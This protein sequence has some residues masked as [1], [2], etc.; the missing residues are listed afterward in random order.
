MPDVRFDVEA[1]SI[2]KQA[3]GQLT[4]ALDREL[5]VGTDTVLG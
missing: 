2:C 5:S 3:L 1:G 4:T